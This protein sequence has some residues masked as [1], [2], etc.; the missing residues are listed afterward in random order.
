MLQ[1]TDDRGRFFIVL[2]H[3]DAG[4][5]IAPL[6]CLLRRRAIAAL[7]QTQDACGAG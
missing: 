7:A 6:S 4:S 5:A 2:E 3:A 1:Y